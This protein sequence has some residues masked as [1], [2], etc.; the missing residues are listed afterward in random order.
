MNSKSLIKLHTRYKIKCGS[1]RR[2]GSTLRHIWSVLR[3][4]CPPGHLWGFCSH[5]LSPPE[6]WPTHLWICSWLQV[7]QGNTTVLTVVDRFSKMTIF[8]ALPKLPSAKETAE[9]NHVFEVHSFPRDIVLDQG[10]QFVLR[11]SREFCRLI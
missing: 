11:L 9:V 10:P 5:C 8:I 6:N 4:K 7:C 3:T 1:Y 2:P